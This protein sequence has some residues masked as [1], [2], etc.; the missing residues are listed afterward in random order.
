MHEIAEELLSW[1]AALAT[2]DGRL[3]SSWVVAMWSTIEQE[4]LGGMSEDGICLETLDGIEQ[5]SLAAVVMGIYTGV[6]ETDKSK[7]MMQ[8][9]IA[10]YLQVSWGALHL[11]LPTLHTYPCI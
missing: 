9:K 6:L 2:I 5:S 8:L 4:M 10:D 11:P 7:I 1:P 3:Q